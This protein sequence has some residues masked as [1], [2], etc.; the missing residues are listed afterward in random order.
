MKN[1]VIYFIVIILILSQFVSAIDKL[2]EVQKVIEQKNAR[3]TAGK[4]WVSELSIEEFRQ[5]CG[6]QLIP[7][8]ADKFPLI[9]LQSEDTLPAALDWRNNNGNWITPIKDQGNCGSCWAFAAI[10]HLESWWKIHNENPDSVI[11]LSEQFAV[12]CSGAG[13]CD[14]G[15]PFLVLDYCTYGGISH[16]FCFPYQAADIPCEGACTDWIEQAV[17]IPHWGWVTMDQGIVENVKI[18]VS[19]Q[20][21]SAAFTVYEDF[22]YYN[23]GIYEHAWGDAV[24]GHCIQIIGWIDSTQCWI[25]KNSWGE[26]WGET[27]SFTPH[28]PG[29]GDGGYF[30]IKWDDCDINTYVPFIFE[31]EPGVIPLSASPEYLD[32]SLTVGDSVSKSFSLNNTGNDTIEYFTLP[33]SGKPMFHITEF[34]TSLDDHNTCWWCGDDQLNGYGNMW[35]QYLDTPI[36]NLSGT[37]NPSISA[38]VF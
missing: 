27:V 5:L 35:L 30:R 8:D 6:A 28:T 12:S 15:A 31:D 17:T 29:A 38:S 14:G 18:A 2:T 22:R 4:S 23:N 32:L 36:L 3:W 24:S 21:I 34:A 11:D 16:E 13:S 26:N 20:P 25:C 19:R 1:R 33:V 37:L 9:T 7:S 10:A